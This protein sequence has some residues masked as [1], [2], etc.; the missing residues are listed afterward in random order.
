M[1][2]IVVQAHEEDACRG[3]RLEARRTPGSTAGDANLEAFVE[4]T[5]HH[6]D[7]DLGVAVLYK[8]AGVGCVSLKIVPLHISKLLQ[9]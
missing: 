1:P 7:H 4:L 3:C 6:E 5:A 2:W 8:P 9:E